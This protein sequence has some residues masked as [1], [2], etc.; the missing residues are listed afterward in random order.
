MPPYQITARATM[1]TGT[2]ADGSIRVTPWSKSDKLERAVPARL[3]ASGCTTQQIEYATITISEQSVS[4]YI[5][6]LS[7]T[8]ESHVLD[9]A[10]NRIYS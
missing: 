2:R 4:A 8:Q 5:T 9:S 7:P 6:F 1:N 10:L 3:S